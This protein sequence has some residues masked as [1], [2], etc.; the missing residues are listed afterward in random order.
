MSKRQAKYD[1]R[2]RIQLIKETFQFTQ[3]EL[4]EKER[5]DPTM[6]VV[7]AM[8]DLEFLKFMMDCAGRQAVRN[9]IAASEVR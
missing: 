4:S 7:L 5:S 1:R 3:E 2:S 6:K 9:M 8:S